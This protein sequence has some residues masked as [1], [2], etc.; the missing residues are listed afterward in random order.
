V[1]V[2]GA[3]FGSP[4]ASLAVGGEWEGYQK[5]THSEDDYCNV[6]KKVG[7][8]L[9]FYVA[10]LQKIKLFINEYQ[11]TIITYIMSVLSI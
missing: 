8:T 9:I 1:D 10:Y 7:K 6:C 2:F 11:R 5:A 3:M 4:Y